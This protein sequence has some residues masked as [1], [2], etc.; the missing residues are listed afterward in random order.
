MEENKIINKLLEMDDR[1]QNIETSILTKEDGRKITE[2]LDHVVKMV[3]RL[4]QERIF[5]TEWVKRI[6]R[7]SESQRQEI[8][9]IKQA[10]NI[11]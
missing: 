11:S 5:T 7:E 8:F 6:E 1:L 10:L 2:T 9:K 4:D 3:G